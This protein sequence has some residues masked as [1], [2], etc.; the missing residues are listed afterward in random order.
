VQ[1]DYRH[2]SAVF[3]TRSSQA[4]ILHAH[5]SQ[6]VAAA[7]LNNAGSPATRIVQLPKECESI[8]TASLG[9]PRVGFLAIMEGAPCSATLVDFVREVVPAV[10][11]QWLKEVTQYQAVKINAVETTALFDKGGPKVS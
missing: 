7:S 5:L 4:A 2:L 11:A 3:V 8:I 9:I 1:V 10:E 6:L